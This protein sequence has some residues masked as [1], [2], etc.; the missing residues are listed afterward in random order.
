VRTFGRDFAVAT[1]R[2]TKP[3]EGR[4][5]RESI[6]WV[7]FP[8]GWRIVAALAGASATDAVQSGG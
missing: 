3:D 2:W 6:T 7:R 5:C 8:Q 4:G 1:I